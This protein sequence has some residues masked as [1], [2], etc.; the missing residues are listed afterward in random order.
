[1]RTDTFGLVYATQKFTRFG[2]LSSFL[3]LI[4]LADSQD[5]QFCCVGVVEFVNLWDPWSTISPHLDRRRH[6]T[7][8]HM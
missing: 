7:D 1:M 3:A 6:Q 2:F 4:H 5:V 8:D